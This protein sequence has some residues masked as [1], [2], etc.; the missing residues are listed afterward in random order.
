[1][2]KADEA[3]V[4]LEVAIDPKWVVT[5]TSIGIVLRVDHPRLGIIDCLMTKESAI[6]LSEILRDIT[7]R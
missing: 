5:M 7:G 3:I 2:K 1:M 6:G 4:V